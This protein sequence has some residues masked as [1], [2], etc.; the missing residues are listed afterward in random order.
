MNAPFKCG[1]CG[2]TFKYRPEYVQHVDAD[3]W[4]FNDKTDPGPM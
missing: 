1:Y 2:K 3:H 4:E